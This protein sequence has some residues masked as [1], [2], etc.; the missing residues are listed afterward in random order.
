MCMGIKLTSQWT[1]QA[2]KLLSVII[3]DKQLKFLNYASPR[4]RKSIVL[5]LY[6]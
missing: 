2:T 1:K 6:L 4:Y 5:Y 3:Y